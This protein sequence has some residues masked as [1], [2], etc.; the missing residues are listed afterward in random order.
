MIRAL[1]VGPDDDSGAASPLQEALMLRRIAEHDGPLLIAGITEC[2]A[3]LA[4]IG[5]GELVL[6][7]GEITEAGGSGRVAK[8]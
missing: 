1:S 4:L 8:P 7:S 5:R 2:R 6:V 3:A